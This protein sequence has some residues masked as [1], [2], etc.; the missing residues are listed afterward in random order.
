MPRWKNYSKVDFEYYESLNL[1]LSSD[2][3][4][5]INSPE[6]KNFK[7]QYFYKFGELPTDD[8]YYGY[9]MMLYFGRMIDKYGTQF[10]KNI[11]GEPFEGLHT[12]FEFLPVGAANIENPDDQYQSNQ[13][14]TII[15]FKDF[16]FQKAE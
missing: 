9:D 2:G 15:K 5:D 13:H 1:H 4:V 14:V 3:F 6:S 8:A 11:D 16:Y 10:Q 12:R 7:T